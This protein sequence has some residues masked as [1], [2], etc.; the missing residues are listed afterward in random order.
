[1]FWK[2]YDV[3][4]NKK[5]CIP[6]WDKLTK[7]QQVKAWAGIKKYDSYLKSLKWSR[8]KADPDTYLRQEYWE[9][10]YK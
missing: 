7:T 9:N 10:E 4:V 1:M 8:P 2:A 3:K 6:I 5:R